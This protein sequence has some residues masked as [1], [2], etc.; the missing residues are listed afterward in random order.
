M[1]GTSG[2][3][4]GL[5]NKGWNLEGTENALTHP[6]ANL[7]SIL[8]AETHDDE[9]YLVNWFAILVAE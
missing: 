3:G 5:G 7:N 8:N 1:R 4:L 2:L 9:L 6:N